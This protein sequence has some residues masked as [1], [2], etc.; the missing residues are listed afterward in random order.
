MDRKEISKIVFRPNFLEIGLFGL[1]PC[2]DT[3]RL[4]DQ[5]PVS[6]ISGRFSI[7][8]QAGVPNH[9]LLNPA[10]QSRRTQWA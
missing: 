9:H 4:R 5:F 10:R 7:V 6:K 1:R 3:D 8:D 2:S